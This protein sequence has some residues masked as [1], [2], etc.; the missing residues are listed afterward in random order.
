MPETATLRNFRLLCSFLNAYSEKLMLSQS[1]DND[2][3]KEL[4]SI[5]QLREYK[6]K[7]RAGIDID[8]AVYEDARCK[9][10]AQKKAQESE[11]RIKSPKDD[12]YGLPDSPRLDDVPDTKRAKTAPQKRR[13][14]L[15]QET[16]S[17]RN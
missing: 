9:D 14:K 13:S 16:L 2:A 8:F 4:F 6:E 7:R 10:E 11:F 15:D 3:E 12:P 5:E 1:N 17:K